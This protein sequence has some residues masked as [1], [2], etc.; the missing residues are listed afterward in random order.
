M[1]I[2]RNFAVGAVLIGAASA[3]IRVQL[4]RVKNVHEQ[5]RKLGSPFNVPP[6]LYSS[7]TKGP[8]MEPLKNY[9]N[10]QYYGNI[11]LGTPPQVFSVIFDTGSS[12]L[13]VPSSKCPARVPGCRV[14]RKY[15][16]SR[17]S[18]YV[19]NGTHFEIE[20][21]S[22]AVAGELSIDTLG[23]G[24]ARVKG[25]MFAEV[26]EEI[27]PA[28]T[29]G[30]FDGILGLGYP[31]G[32]VLNVTPVFDNMVAQGLAVTRVFAFYLNRNLSDPSG[33]EVLFGGVDKAHY[34]GRVTYLP[35][36]K[37]GYWQFKMDGIKISG[38]TTFCKRGCQAIADT[39]TSA[40]VGP[41]DEIDKLN[42]RIRAKEVSPGEYVVNCKSLPHLPKI[43]F[44]LNKREFVLDPEDYVFKVTENGTTICLS[45][46]V[47]MDV[48]LPLGPLWILGDRFIGRYY[49]IFDRGNDRV[50]FA[51]AR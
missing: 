36:T 46:F 37:K 16:S 40:I 45:G 47:A 43:S 21:G 23:I 33:G 1:Q 13:W 27:S 32:A 19:Q 17:S 48:P 11:T 6:A 51:D 12:N 42:R 15:H 49:T 50:G 5:Y 31:Q 7:N 29:I 26:T 39:G 22:G 14:H 41:S 38:K 28:F 35:V 3:L 25:Q 8:I 34:K 10:A 4:H 18:T 30:K 24:E 9:V 20:Y 44:N 2:L